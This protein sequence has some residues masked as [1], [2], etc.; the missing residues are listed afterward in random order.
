MEV[1]L[2]QLMEVVVTKDMLK[3]LEVV[4]VLE[5]QLFQED[6]PVTLKVKQY[7]LLMERMISPWAMVKIIC[8][9]MLTV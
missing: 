3:L 6:L 5:L 9:P 4:P 1:L 7:S 2:L 8:S